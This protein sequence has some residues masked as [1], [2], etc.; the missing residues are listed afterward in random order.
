MRIARYAVDET[1]RYGVADAD[2]VS[3]LIGDPFAGQVKPSGV[4]HNLGDVRLLAPVLPRSKVVSLTGGGLLIKP[5]T[6]VVGPGEAVQ[7]PA[8]SAPVV[9]GEL[10]IVIARICRSVPVARAPE[11]IFGYTAAA[12]VLAP[13]KVAGGQ[14]WGLAGSWDTFT[15]LGPWVVTHLSLEEAGTL[16]IVTQAGPDKARRTTTKDLHFGIAQAVA[17]VSSVMTLLPGDVIL[18][19]DAGPSL[20]LAAGETVTVEIEEIGELSNPVIDEAGYGA[21]V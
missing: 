16:G 10:A 18:A 15:P 4:R 11:V 14:P 2:A 17:L 20:P 7:I 21:R 6:S 19:G 12:N 9:T 1:M 13:D 5:N 3:D 8:S